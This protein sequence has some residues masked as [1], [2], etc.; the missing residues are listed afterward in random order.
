MKAGLSNFTFQQT[1]E[2]N[3][4]KQGQQDWD[5]LFNQTKVNQQQTSTLAE[6]KNYLKQIITTASSSTSSA[7]ITTPTKTTTTSS[8]TQSIKY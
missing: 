1:P 3:L 8:K 2:N 6:I 5:T 7:K 4:I